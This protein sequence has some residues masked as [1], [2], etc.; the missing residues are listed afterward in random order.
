MNSTKRVHLI[1]QNKQMK[2]TISI[3]ILLFIAIIN[4]SAQLPVVTFT[5]WP[6]ATTTFDYPVLVTNCGDSRTF[7]VQ[8]NGYIYIVDSLGN[9]LAT[10]YLN[11]QSLCDYANYNEEGLLGLAFDPD[12]KNNGYFYINYTGSEA[13]PG[14]THIVRYSVSATDPNVAD[15]AS[16]FELLTF[17][18][19]YV[20]HNG[21]MLAFGPDGYLYDGQGDG[22][23]GGDP[24]NLAQNKK[25][26]LGKIL[27]IDPHAGTPYGIPPSNPF[28]NDTVNYYP[29]IWDLGMRNPWRFSFD[30]ITG[31]FWIG[32]VGQ[33]AWEEINF[34]PAG[35]A[36]GNNYG[37]RCYEGNHS[38]ITSGCQPQSTY[39]PPIYE[40]SHTGGYCSIT[41]GYVYRGAQFHDLWGR[42]LYTDY[43]KGILWSL[44]PDVGGTW[45]N[46]TLGQFLSY[47]YSSFGEDN[48]GELYICAHSLNKV[49]KISSNDCKP[50]AYILEKDS[51]GICLGTALHS[52]YGIGL[53]YQW[54]LNA[55]D[56]VGAT[57]SQYVPTSDGSYSVIVTKTIC[58][59]T[60]ANI[61]I[62]VNQLPSVSFSAPGGDT[63][64]CNNGSA[65]TLTG[66]PSGG[67]FSGLGMT[68]NTF[69]PNGLTNGIDTIQYFYTDSLGC[70]NSTTNYFSIS[71]CV[72]MGNINALSEVKIFPSPNNGQFNLSFQSVKFQM[73][74]IEIS[75]AY[76]QIQFQKSLNVS[77]GKS[78][79]KINLN[80]IVP[81]VYHYTIKGNE[82]FRNGSFI[83]E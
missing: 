49:F 39:N 9:K 61:F 81:G 35:S 4:A 79:Q 77:I 57:S 65:V 54:Q 1:F 44:L 6:S 67:I 83:V 68:G 46:D 34:E 31:D 52:I 66:I 2:K 45:N 75:N 19:P 59:D 23:G 60:S 82:V 27:R 56:I 11:M 55:I 73:I 42:Y 37:W 32:D 71:T 22:G 80:H 50:V 18:Q 76:G 69:N 51:S 78:E 10:P 7:V 25:T 30:R 64:Y 20:N 14:P 8:R 15:P 72:G 63:A 41:G 3:S 53:S 5:Q 58:S 36:G 12:Y 47:T 74:E 62:T 48:S 43:C 16:A 38:F 17:S 40:Y 28:A 29:E 26:F 33:I 24:Q 13:N 21:G 70:S